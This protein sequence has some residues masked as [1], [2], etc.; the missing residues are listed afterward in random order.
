MTLCERLVPLHTFSPHRP[1]NAPAVDDPAVDDPALL[2]RNDE[3]YVSLGFQTL[4]NDAKKTITL[5]VGRFWRCW[6]TAAKSLWKR[7]CPDQRWWRFR[8]GR[9]ATRAVALGQ[10]GQSGRHVAVD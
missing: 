9:S 2:G 5:Q 10:F 7:L 1:S 3:R 4:R 8:R 6:S